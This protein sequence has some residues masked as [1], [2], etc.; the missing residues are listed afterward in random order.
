M[1][2]RIIAR[3]NELSQLDRIYHSD[4]SEFVAIYG[5]R[6]VGKTYLVREYF[7]GNIVFQ[8]SG[9]SSQPTKSQLK[10][11]HRKWSFYRSC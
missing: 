5:R 6:R 9:L 3:E 7:E 11:F 8:C 2:E 10:N 1:R 4:K